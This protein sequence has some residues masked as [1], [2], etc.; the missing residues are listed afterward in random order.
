M[1]AALGTTTWA[2]P[3]E[4]DGRFVTVVQLV[5]FKSEFCSR[6]YGV[7]S[8]AQETIA[9]PLDEQ[10]L[11]GGGTTKYEKLSISNTLSASKFNDP[12]VPGQ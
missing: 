12:P 6:T 9:L 7:V 5:V 4:T 11:N 10:I 1:P 8:S 2:R 3:S